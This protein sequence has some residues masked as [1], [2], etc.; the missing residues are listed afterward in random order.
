MADL[1]IKI[2]VNMYLAFFPQYGQIGAQYDQGCN[3]KG[4]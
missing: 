1:G 2:Q 4:L 3:R